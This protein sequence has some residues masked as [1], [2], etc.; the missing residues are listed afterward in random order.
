MEPREPGRDDKQ[1]WPRRPGR[2]ERPTSE[3]EASTSPQ[4]LLPRESPPGAR[5]LPVALILPSLV[6]MVV[7]VGGRR[8]GDGPG[9]YGK[10]QLVLR[11]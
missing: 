1:H 5:T 8:K 7:P 10:I 2:G 6:P 4:A 3:G 9:E 11:S